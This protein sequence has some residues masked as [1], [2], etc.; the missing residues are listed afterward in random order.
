MIDVTIED[1]KYTIRSHGPGDWE[2][3]RHGEPWPAFELNGPDNLHMALATHVAAL[4]EQHAREIAALESLR[5]HWAQGYSS[6]SV[7]A[8]ASTA[9]LSQLWDMLKVKSQTDAVQCLQA[10][11]DYGAHGRDWQKRALAAED[12]ASRLRFPDTT[13]Q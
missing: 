9:A 11:L 7:A 8:Q 10:L 4:T 2:V 5:P 13:G 3:L 1:G 6:D 12:D